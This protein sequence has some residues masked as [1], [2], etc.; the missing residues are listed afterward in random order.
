M[1][2]GDLDARRGPQVAH[3]ERDLRRAAHAV[4][5]ERA[6]AVGREHF[7][8]HARE[9]DRALARFVADDDAALAR[10]SPR[11]SMNWHSAWAASPMVRVL[12]RFGP[13]PIAP[14]M[15]PVPMLMRL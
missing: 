1:R 4:E 9:V 12:I 5:A 13:G 6:D 3:G 14:R 11:T 8:A 2:R 10:R 15:P 7:A